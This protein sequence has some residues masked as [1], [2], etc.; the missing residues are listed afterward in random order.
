MIRHPRQFPRPLAASIAALLGA[1]LLSAPLARAQTFSYIGNNNGGYYGSATN[2]S[3][4]GVPNSP[5]AIANIADGDAPGDITFTSG[6]VSISPTVGTLNLSNNGGAGGGVSF[7]NGTLT[8]AANGT[9]NAGG[10]SG[11]VHGSGSGVTMNL[12]GPVTLNTAAD[13][14]FSTV[15]NGGNGF[16]GNGS[17]VKAGAGTYVANSVNSNYTGGT[18]IQAGTVAFDGQGPS[19]AFGAGAVRIEGGMLDYQGPVTLMNAFTIAGSFG[20]TL[21]SATPGTLTISTP[22]TL[23]AGAKTITTTNVGGVVA[24]LAFTDVL[25]GAG[26]LVKAG[27]GTLRL[28][29]G[30][31]YIGNT[32]LQA[33]TL[34]VENDAALGPGALRVEGGTLAFTANRSL[35][36]PVT[37]AGPLG[38]AGVDAAG[39]PV[40]TLTLTGGVAIEGIAVQPITVAT[41][42]TDTT[43]D[44]ASVISGGGGLELGSTGPR[45]ARVELTSGA[46]NTF[47]GELRVN[48]A[49]LTANLGKSAGFAAPGDLNLVAGRVE[50][51]NANRQVGGKVTSA[52]GTTLAPRTDQEFGQVAIA[53]AITGIGAAPT[54]LT[55]GEGSISGQISDP[56]AELTLRKISP[57]T[58]TLT[59]VNSY[60]GGVRLE[61]GVLEINQGAALG[62]AGARFQAG[63]NAG[64]AVTLRTIGAAVTTDRPFTLDA[65]LITDTA[66]A[67]LSLDGLVD[68]AGGLVKTGPQTLTLRNGGNTFVGGVDVRQGTLEVFGDGSLGA[69][70][71]G[72]RLEAATTLRLGAALS[73]TR[74]VTLAD[75]AVG[76]VS[77]GPIELFTGAFDATLGGTISGISSAAGRPTLRKTGAGTVRFEGA[78]AKS[79][80]DLDVA[81][82]R[83]LV[84][85]GATIASDVAVRAGAELAGDG[86]IGDLLAGGGNVINAGLVS[87]GDP[88]QAR[89]TGTLRLSGAY[90]QAAT[91]A[92]QIEIA[93]RNAGDFDVLA[94]GG[95][96]RVDGAV[97]F[98]SLQGFMPRAGDRFVFLTAGAGVTG[99]F[100]TV[101]LDAPLIRGRV[102]YGANE[103]ALV[104]NRARI[105][106][107]FK[108]RDPD[109]VVPAPD[110]RLPRLTL[111]QTRTAKELD[112]GINDPALGRLFDELD[113][114]SLAGIPTALD[115]I[116]PE[117]YSVIYEV[118][119][120]TANVQAFNLARHL[121]DLQAGARGFS[122][123]DLRLAAVAEGPNPRPTSTGDGALAPTPENR[124]SVFL[125]GSGEKVDL[126]SDSNARGYHFTTGG[127]TLGAD[128]RVAE[129][130]AIGLFTGYANTDAE[131]RGDGH[132]SVD[133]AKLGLYAAGWGERWA[134]HALVAGGYND[135]D[136]KREGLG[137][138]VRGDTHGGE[139]TAAFSGRF[140]AVRLGGAGADWSFRAGPLL[141]GQFTTVGYEGFD[142]HGSAAPLRIA[143]NRSD[144]LRT[145]LGAQAGAA[146]RIRRWELRTVGQAFW[147]HEYGDR[148]RATDADL[149]G[150]AGRTFQV[151]GPRTGR[152]S[153][154]L[155]ASVSVAPSERFSTYVA[156]D[157]QLGQERLTSHT[158]SAGVKLQF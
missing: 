11:G 150:G 134:A 90:T 120:A 54:T 100:S 12:A 68:G 24:T 149:P 22:A 45:A 129:R 60:R 30:N 148:T 9:I 23:E 8:I 73:T 17:L 29:A 136:M 153:L 151:E 156:Y 139:F 33:G 82:G 5:T 110:A 152:D 62:A 121:D 86:Q 135:Y 39:N 10:N 146:R 147:Q 94:V 112:R 13:I 102:I 142:E 2:W 115:L 117:E 74:A 131:L 21:S 43:L 137:G 6:G 108:P 80:F 145:R 87:P 116:A 125:S 119:I 96:A 123:H 46:G 157:G 47:T 70:T 4:N 28:A 56:G 49:N 91:G 141:E 81:Q 52:A 101:Q 89:P 77:R 118:G 84:A 7:L 105:V 69:A 3:P 99:R 138:D 83:A 44:I 16:A 64:A 14:A 122:S 124:W 55:V 114:F 18:T 38:V 50:F 140:D 92:L 103:A 37:L 144:A 42:G 20:V 26:G 31:T 63:L 72:L 66:A 88:A 158:L 95:Q 127:F 106:P 133:S 51:S 109:P 107:I 98:V 93:G 111:N 155:N 85:M 36:N 48:G 97:R 78:G 128:Y 27:D 58:L 126:D 154:I 132:V 40:Q 1:V 65:T 34:Q 79:G 35:A 143:D 53:G 67:A 59:G 41:A 25:S 130:F 19:G 15:L 57:A 32:T 71:G 75:V 76:G 113:R 61:G 104:F